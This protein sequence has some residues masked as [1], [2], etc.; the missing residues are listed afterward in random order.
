MNKF[1]TTFIVAA[2]FAGVLAAS[3]ATIQ[4]KDKKNHKAY[5]IESETL[6][7]IGWESARKVPGKRLYIWDVESV[8]YDAD[9]MDEYN[10]LQRKLEG[11]RGAKLASDAKSYLGDSEMPE[12]LSKDEWARIQLQAQ[13]YYAQGLF[14]QSQYDD[15][16]EAFETYLKD[17]EKAAET[18]VDRALPSKVISKSAITGKKIANVSSLNRFF[19]DGLEA[20]GLAYL[21]KGEADKAMKGAF[22]LLQ[23]ITDTLGRAE[24]FDWS[25]R[26]LRSAASYAEQN[27]NYADARKSYEQLELV[28]LRKASG[29][30][31]RTSIEANLKV[32]YMLVAEGKTR[33]AKSRFFKAIRAWETQVKALEKNPGAPKKNWID[34]DLAY[35]TSGAY[36]GQGLVMLKEAEKSKKVEDYTEALDSFSK[37]IALFNADSEIR[38]MALLGAARASQLLEGKAKTDAAKELYGKWTARY[39]LEL[40]ALH[41][42]SK[43]IDSEWMKEIRK[44]ANKYS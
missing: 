27:D 12:K 42:D 38:S 24:A 18:K 41:G 43:T 13:Y 30:A 33:D 8:R 26:A 21:R 6:S 28:A 11:G 32:G 31:T 35:E 14:L 7:G 17:A 1:I 23:D 15:A 19:L 2:A 4:M 16:I 34:S 36:V 10:G 3:G 25:L 39:V 40:D 9:G 37:S 5:S 29:R 44:T 22:A 20:L